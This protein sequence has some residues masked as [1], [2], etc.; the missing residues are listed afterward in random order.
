MLIEG[1]ARTTARSIT[2]DLPGVPGCPYVL[3]RRQNWSVA[4][5]I[6]DKVEKILARDVAMAVAVGDDI[7]WYGAVDVTVSV[8]KD[9]T[10]GNWVV[11]VR[12]GTHE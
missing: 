2:I 8:I 6:A 3:P 10:R 12:E 11:T 4:D 1:T 9:I 5:D 7:P